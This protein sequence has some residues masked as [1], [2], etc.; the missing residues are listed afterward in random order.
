ME[1]AGELVYDTDGALWQHAW[2]EAARVAEA[3]EL[4]RV[5]VAIDPAGGQG[6]Q[7]AQTGIAAG[8]VGRDGHAYVTHLEGVQL[9]PLGWFLRACDLYDAVGADALVVEQNYGGPFIRELAREHRP[10]VHVVF[11]SATRGKVVRAEP[12]AARYQKGDVHHVGLLAEG[13]AQLCAFPVSRR[14]DMADATVWLVSHLLGPQ[15]PV[16]A[17]VSFGRSSPWRFRG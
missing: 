3:P 11:V 12:I 8:G 17:P 2:I 1:L 10:D 16:V 9:S 7:S 15:V 4:T 14:K 5:V 6:N 13:E